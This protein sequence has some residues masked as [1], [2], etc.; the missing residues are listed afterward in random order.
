MSDWKEGANKRR[1]A[2]HTKTDDEPKRSLKPAKTKKDTKRWCR[3][4]IGIEHDAVCLTYDEAKS[5]NDNS[6]FFHKY[7]AQYRYLVCKNCGKE[8]ATYYGA[9]NQKKPDWV[10]K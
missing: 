7:M 9:S 8:L 6:G 10:T 5:V 3:G 2:R 1:D 4:K